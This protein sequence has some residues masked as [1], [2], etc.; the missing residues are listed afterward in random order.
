MENNIL[1]LNDLKVYIVKKYF[2]KNYSFID[3]NSKGL[4]QNKVE[5]ALID[6]LILYTIIE[7][8]KIFQPFRIISKNEK[9]RNYLKVW[10][11]LVGKAKLYPLMDKQVIDLVNDYNIDKDEI[12][13]IVFCL[14]NDGLKLAQ[15]DSPMLHKKYKGVK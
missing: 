5:Y 15:E 8:Y 10:D 9:I 7:A 2:N 11:D 4:K 13:S 12:Y 6:S 1:D 14:I 3:L